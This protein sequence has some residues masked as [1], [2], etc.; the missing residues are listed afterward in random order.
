MRMNHEK[1]QKFMIAWELVQILNTF[2][3]TTITFIRSDKYQDAE[4]LLMSAQ[5]SYLVAGN[6]IPCLLVLS[7][8]CIFAKI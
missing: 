2:V 3:H 1:Y 8:N 5:L 7:M 6:V 4:R